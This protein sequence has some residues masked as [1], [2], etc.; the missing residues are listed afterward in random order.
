MSPNN[1]VDIYAAV[2]RA[3]QRRLTP[4]ER[5]RLDRLLDGFGLA[6]RF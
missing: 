5:A 2:Q 1:R 4:D 3:L 6:R